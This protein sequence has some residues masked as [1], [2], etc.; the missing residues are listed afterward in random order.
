MESLP[1]DSSE[2]MRNDTPDVLIRDMRRL[3]GA[4]QRQK[5]DGCDLA[6]AACRVQIGERCVECVS[7]SVG[8]CVGEKS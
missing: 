5:M 4:L 8:V 1:Q 6:A 3:G 2:I 7:K